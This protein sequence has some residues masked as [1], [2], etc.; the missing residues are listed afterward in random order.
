MRDGAAKHSETKAF[1]RKQISSGDDFPMPNNKLSRTIKVATTALA[2]GVASHASAISFNAGDAKVDIYGYARLNAVYDIDESISR[3]TGTQSGDFSRINTG[4]AENNE[5][6]GHFDADAVQS[7]IG[8]RASLPTGVT[9][10]I[11]GDFRGGSSG[12]VLRLR[13]AYGKYKNWLIGQ[14]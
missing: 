14:T 7:R 5:V 10:N 12:G 8:V 2:M 13:H 3:A 9:V 1:Q 6:T 4:A 11:E